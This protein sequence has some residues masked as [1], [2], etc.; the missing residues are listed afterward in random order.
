MVSSL[1]S[2]KYYTASIDYVTTSFI[3]EYDI[4]KADISIFLSKGAITQEQFN[5]LARIPSLARNIQM[6]LLQ[7]ERP[8]LKKVLSKGI[9]EIRQQFFEANDVQDYEVLSIKNDAIFLINKVAEVTDFGLVHLKN[10]NTYNS[11]YK[12]PRKFNKEFYYYYNRITAE[13]KLDIKGMG[14][15][16]QELHKDYMIEFLT[17]LF[18]SIEIFPLDDS[19]NLLQIFHNQ[20]IN[21]ELDIGY[22]RKFDQVSGF[23]TILESPILKHRYNLRHL[24]EEHR[25]MID[26]TYNSSMIIEFYKMVANMY[27]SQK[28]Q[29]K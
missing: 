16:E 3:R 22:Y 17:V 14:K 11:F 29:K 2:K 8:E 15:E 19:I 1:W 12:L 28:G 24:S 21:Q 5:F 26:I 10:K 23:D 7:Q 25:E 9:E 18:N 27:F 6:G 13:E 20:Y 4:S